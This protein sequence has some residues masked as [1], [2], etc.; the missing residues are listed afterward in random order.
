MT[1]PLETAPICQDLY[2]FIKS[3]R[4][5]EFLAKD[6]YAFVKISHLIAVVMVGPPAA[7][8]C[9]SLIQS[10]IQ[11]IDHSRDIRRVA[12]IHII[13]GTPIDNLLNEPDTHLFGSVIELIVTHQGS[14]G[15]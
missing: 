15:H 12:C 10:I 3:A 14:A 4:L 2:I 13:Q 11:S 9:K 8:V 6:P 5:C 1:P 7:T